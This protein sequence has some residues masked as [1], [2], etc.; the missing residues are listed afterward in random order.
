MLRLTLPIWFNAIKGLPWSKV[1]YFPV[2]RPFVP[3]IASYGTTRVRQ[4]HFRV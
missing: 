4:F 1:Q 2:C 3:A